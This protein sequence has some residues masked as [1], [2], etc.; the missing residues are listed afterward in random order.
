MRHLLKDTFDLRRR[1]SVLIASQTVSSSLS[2]TRNP[3]SLAAVMFELSG[4]SAGTGTVFVNGTDSND[5]AQSEQL[6]FAGNGIKQTLKRYKTLTAVTT[7]GLADEAT[8]GTISG[9]AVTLTGEEIYY[10]SP[11][12]TT[13]AGRLMDV[14]GNLVYDPRGEVTNLSKKMFVEYNS[15]SFTEGDVVG[16]T[17]LGWYKVEYAK[18]LSD[19]GNYHH[20]ELGLTD[21]NQ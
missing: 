10:D 8:K 4:A 21:Y 1:T 12:T 16:S 6:T 13:I 9:K 14:R 19:F 3:D 5:V 2:L 11:T 20:Y 17:T 15:G 18:L 7:S